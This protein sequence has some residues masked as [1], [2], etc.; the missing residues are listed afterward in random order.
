MLKLLS[1]KIK[2]NPIGNIPVDVMAI[3]MVPV[4]K[5]GITSKTVYFTE[6]VDLY[7]SLAKNIINEKTFRDEKLTK[8]FGRLFPGRLMDVDY[9]SEH[10]LEDCVD[11]YTKFSQD[12]GI[13][14]SPKKTIDLQPVYKLVF[15]LKDRVLTLSVP[16]SAHAEKYLQRRGY[17]DSSLLNWGFW[18]SSFPF[19]L[20]NYNILLE[21]RKDPWIR[22]GHLRLYAPAQEYMRFHSAVQNITLKKFDKQI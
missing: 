12:Y 16:K 9:I 21:L 2:E 22:S 13:N 10:S 18:A 4:F 5:D 14:C 15:T 3:Q 1:G 7:L 19:P 8:E 6:D 11:I 20:Y 17:D